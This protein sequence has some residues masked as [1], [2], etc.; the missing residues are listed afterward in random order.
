MTTNTSL[1]SAAADLSKSRGWLI[2]GGI[3]SIFVGFS[4]IGSPLVF[5]LVI[6]QFLGVVALVSGVIALGLAIF[7]KHKG[8]RV[9]EALTGIIRIAAGIVLLNCLATSVMMITLIFAFFL[10]IEGV[11]V[12][13]TAF[14]MR[15][16]PGWVWM[17]ISGLASL[18]LGVMVYNRWPSDSAAVLGFFFGISLLFNGSSLL[19]LGLSAGKPAAA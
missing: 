14:M 2:A 15:N 3:L 5:S 18:I 9:M 10:I 7:G 8:H 1:P 4:A 19:A 13:A 12:S 17:L 11:F 16:T 6:A